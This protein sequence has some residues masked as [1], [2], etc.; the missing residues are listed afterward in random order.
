MITALY[1]KPALLDRTRH[2]GKHLL[3]LDA[4]VAAGMNA[5]FC[6]FGEFVEAGKEYPILFV[7]SGTTE[8]G[9]PQLNPVVLLGLS[10]G[11][12]LFV[13]GS[14]WFGRYVPAALRC[15][16]LGL[17]RVARA[18]GTGDELS[19]VIDESYTGLVDGPQGVPLLSATGEP[20][21]TLTNAMKLLEL[22]DQEAQRTPLFCERL[23]ELDLLKGMRAEGTLN[24]GEAFSVDGFQVVDEDKLRA[25]PD[26]T[27]LELYRNGMLALIYAHLGSLSCLQRLSDRKTHLKTQA[28]AA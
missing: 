14:Q 11:E 15:Y 2:A 17:T 27:V 10:P 8:S 25:L 22:Y 28:A 21:E 6:T 7:N 23:R 20:T 19:V 9:G 4:S 24:D 26:A 18:D 12:N 1:K 3:P 16:P 5:L 13:E